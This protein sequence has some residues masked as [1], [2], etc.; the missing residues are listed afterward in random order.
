MQDNTNFLNIIECENVNDID[1]GESS[2][3][4]SCLFKLLDHSSDDQV[5]YEKSASLYVRN[6]SGD[7]SA[8][9]SCSINDKSVS[10]VDQFQKLLI[11]EY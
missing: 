7:S 1:D 8:Y 11:P 9:R 4:Y 2:K 10:L 6:R 5:E 3:E